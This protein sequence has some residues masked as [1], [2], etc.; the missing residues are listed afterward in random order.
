LESKTTRAE[1]GRGGRDKP[2]GYDGCRG[3]RARIYRVETL[4]LCPL[5]YGLKMGI[6][7]RIRFLDIMEERRRGMQ[8]I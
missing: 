1:K 5:R 4:D 7:G 8:H 3:L 2:I 6:K